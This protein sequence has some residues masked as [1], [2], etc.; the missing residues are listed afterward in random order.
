[1]PDPKG[2]SVEAVRETRE[3]IGR[4]VKELAAEL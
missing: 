2:Q 3:E 4:R 1:L